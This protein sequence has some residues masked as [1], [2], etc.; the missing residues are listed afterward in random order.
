M[1]LREAIKQIVKQ[2]LS[3]QLLIG[4]VKSVDEQK[5]TCVIEPVNDGVDYYSVRLSANKQGMIIIPKIGSFVVLGML[6]NQSNNYMILGYT[7]IKK[8][9][10]TTENNGT[11]ELTDLGEIFLNGN[12]LG[13][14]VKWL[15]LKIE[16]EK[17]KV[18]VDTIIQAFQTAPTAAQDG[19]ATFKTGLVTA[20]SALTA[21]SYNNLENTKVKHGE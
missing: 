13:G 14:L 16:L 6:E 1:S 12:N 10:I 5:H 11:M 8:L 4:T 7:E 20:T 17:E 2:E 18:R 19:G 3:E 21:P 9:K 15:N